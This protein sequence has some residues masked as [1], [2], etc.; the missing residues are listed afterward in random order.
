MAIVILFSMAGGISLG[1]YRR[2]YRQGWR[3][4][5]RDR[6]LQAFLATALVT[7]LLLSCSLRYQDGFRWSAALGHGALN[8]LS[9]QSTAGFSSTPIAPL[10]DGAKLSLILAMFTGGSMGSTA[11]GIK[12]LRL[13][14]ILRLV[15]L[16]IKQAGSPP[17]A[18]SEARLGGRRLESDEIQGVLCILALFMGITF[19]S[20]LAFVMM[21]H[22]S[23]DSLFEVVS[24]IGTAGLSTGITSA[25]LHPLLKGVLCADML[26]GRLEIMVW[27]VVLY[28]GT[29]L[30]IRREQ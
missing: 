19:L 27:L 17:N 23:L 28:P 21:G 3:T 16:L 29:W 12:I 11:G 26:L 13:L 10:G 9:A 8:A 14:M 22:P 24:A 1:L 18:V 2:A 6:Q 15:T 30:G 5:L 4:V 25:Q 20:W 7:T